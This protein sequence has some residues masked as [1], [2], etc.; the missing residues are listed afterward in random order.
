MELALLQFTFDALLGLADQVGR[1][2][3]EIVG[4]VQFGGQVDEFFADVHEGAVLVDRVVERK[5]VV[6]VV[7]S[8]GRQEME[9]LLTSRY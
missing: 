6:V 8:F 9:R 3:L 7:H 1:G 5:D 2:F 4:Q